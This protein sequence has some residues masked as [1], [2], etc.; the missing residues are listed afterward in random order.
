MRDL[1]KRAAKSHSDC[2]LPFLDRNYVP[3]RQEREKKRGQKEKILFFF[4]FLKSRRGSNC[5]FFDDDDDDDDDVAVVFFQKEVFFWS[6]AFLYDF[7]SRRRGERRER[8]G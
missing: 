6:Y 4:Q 8:E 7:L 1:G 5:F 3:A 2:V